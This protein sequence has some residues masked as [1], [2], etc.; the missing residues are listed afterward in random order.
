MTSRNGC[1]S[2]TIDN[3]RNPIYLSPRDFFFS[4]EWWNQISEIL[5]S[6][7]TTATTIKHMETLCSKTSVKIILVLCTFLHRSILLN[8]ISENKGRLGEFIMNFFLLDTTKTI[9]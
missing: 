9:F 5:N 4:F 8:S 7:G 1:S 3:Y 6:F 2:K